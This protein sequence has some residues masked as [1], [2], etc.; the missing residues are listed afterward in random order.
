[1]FFLVLPFI[2]WFERP[3]KLPESIATAVLE[4]SGDDGGGG[5][6][7]PDGAAAKAEDRG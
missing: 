6:G 2:G 5:G 4:S 1:L 3:K 7:A